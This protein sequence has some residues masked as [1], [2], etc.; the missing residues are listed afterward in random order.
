MFK[1]MHNTEAQINRCIEA[2]MLNA[3]VGSEWVRCDRV[4]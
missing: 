4:V 3:C 1:L 2:A